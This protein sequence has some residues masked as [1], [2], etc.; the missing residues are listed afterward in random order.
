MKWSFIQKTVRVGF[1]IQ[2]NT[3]IY[4]YVRGW[5]ASM[6]EDQGTSILQG[7]APG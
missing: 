2:E 5:A 4:I 6:E 3:Y 7:S 1:V